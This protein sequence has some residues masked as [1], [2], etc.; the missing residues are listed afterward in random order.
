MISINSFNFNIMQIIC[1]ENISHGESKSTSL[2]LLKLIEFIEIIG[3][4]Q[5]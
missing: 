2:V 1:Y 4:R 5:I 3:Q